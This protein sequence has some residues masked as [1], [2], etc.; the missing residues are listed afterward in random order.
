MKNVDILGCDHDHG[1]AIYALDTPIKMANC[2]I[3][4]N[5]YAGTTSWSLIKSMVAD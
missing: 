4:G 2:N 1:G 5:R 3:T